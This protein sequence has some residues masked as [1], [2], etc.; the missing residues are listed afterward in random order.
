VP[1]S[2]IAET[3]NKVLYFPSVSISAGSGDIATI[4][5]AAI[6]SGHVLVNCVFNN[7]SRIS[8]DITWTTSDTAPQFK[9]NGTCTAATTANI[10]LAKKDN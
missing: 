7:P 2:R 6:D 4:T 5:N 9:L 8:T 1:S 10:T 3:V